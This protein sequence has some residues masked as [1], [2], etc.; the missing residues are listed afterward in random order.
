[1][2]SSDCRDVEDARRQKLEEAVGRTEA[3]LDA[4]ARKRQSPSGEESAP[5]APQRTS[6]R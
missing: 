1:M 3:D 4:E 6:R 5:Q 2:D